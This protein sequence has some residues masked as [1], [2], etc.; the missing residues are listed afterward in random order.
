MILF[1]GSAFWAYGV[2]GGNAGLVVLTPAYTVE[3]DIRRYEVIL[4][5]STVG[6]Y[7]SSSGPTTYQ[8][9]LYSASDLED[10]NHTLT[11]VNIDAGRRLS[12]DR[13]KHVSGL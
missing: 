9:L 1:S 5:N 3:I 7:N 2:T 11:L 6:V 12:F 8:S 13:L 10:T 4:D